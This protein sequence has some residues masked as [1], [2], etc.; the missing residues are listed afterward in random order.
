MDLIS[1]APGINLFKAFEVDGGR[2][3]LK[4]SATGWN[5]CHGGYETEVAR[6]VRIHGTPTWTD[7]P[8]DE[9]VKAS[10]RDGKVFL[11]LEG[12]GYGKAKILFRLKKGNLELNLP[13]VYI[14]LKK[15]T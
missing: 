11:L 3:Y 2:E 8:H 1:G 7:L 13:P 14:D 10:V 6:L 12:A 9:L 15:V 4:D 5:Q